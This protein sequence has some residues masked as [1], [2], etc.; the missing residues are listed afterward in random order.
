MSDVWCESWMLDVDEMADIKSS[1]ML[2]VGLWKVVDWLECLMGCVV[3]IVLPSF[4]DVGNS[5]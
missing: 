3:E 4:L 2:F 5:I 1:C